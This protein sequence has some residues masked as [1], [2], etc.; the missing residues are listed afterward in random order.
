MIRK[1][2]EIMTKGECKTKKNIHKKAGQKI[3]DE[4]LANDTQEAKRKNNHGKR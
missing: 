4:L 3:R 2:S 1:I